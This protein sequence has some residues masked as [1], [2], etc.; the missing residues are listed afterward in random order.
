[1]LDA[2]KSS[3]EAQAGYFRKLCTDV[4]DQNSSQH[5]LTQDAAKLWA[6][7]QVTFNLSN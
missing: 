6:R 3:G 1:M 2:F 5:K 4:M 7:E